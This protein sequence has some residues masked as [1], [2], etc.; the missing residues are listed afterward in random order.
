VS[1]LGDKG[2]KL[3]SAMLGRQL[4]ASYR[5]FLSGV[6]FTLAAVSPER[7]GYLAGNR[8][9]STANFLRDDPLKMP[10]P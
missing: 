10:D 1:Y 9:P 7:K 6:E 8:L 2:I 3:N 5:P 4:R